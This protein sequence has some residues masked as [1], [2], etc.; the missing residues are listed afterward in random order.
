VGLTPAGLRDRL[1]L[2]TAVPIASDR[3]L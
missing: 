2:R 3:P 1:G